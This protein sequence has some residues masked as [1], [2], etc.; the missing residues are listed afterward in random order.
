MQCARPVHAGREMVNRIVFLVSPTPESMRECM[1]PVR[2][3]TVLL[4]VSSC[5]LRGTSEL[6]QGHRLLSFSG[7]SRLLNMPLLAVSLREWRPWRGPQILSASS[8]CSVG[9]LLPGAPSNPLSALDVLARLKS[10]R[11]NRPSRSHTKHSCTRR[12]RNP[13]SH[14]AAFAALSQTLSASSACSVGRLLP[15]A[16]SNPLSALDVLARLKSTRRNRPSRSHTKHSCTRRFRNPQS[17]N[18]AFA[19]LSCPRLGR[20]RRHQWSSSG[21]HGR[22]R[23][24]LSI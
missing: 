19:E 6:G 18:A 3:C 5:E 9:R 2:G 10:T 21:S 20:C 22:L 1:T 12:F 14:N 7:L 17:H 23:S 4:Y 16:P 15:G 11:R 13:Q 24:R 8:A